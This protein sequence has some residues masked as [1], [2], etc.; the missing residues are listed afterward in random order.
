MLHLPVTCSTLFSWNYSPDNGQLVTIKPSYLSLYFSRLPATT[1]GKCYRAMRLKHA[2]LQEEPPPGNAQTH[3]NDKRR[4]RHK[5]AD[6][7]P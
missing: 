3:M 5:R 1:P 7:P 2:V 4:Q 6:D